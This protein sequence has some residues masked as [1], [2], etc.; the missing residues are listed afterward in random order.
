M[1]VR[2]WALLAPL[3]VLALSSCAAP[4]GNAQTDQAAAEAARRISFPRQHSADALVRAAVGTSG[5]QGGFSV[6]QAKDLDAHDLSDPLARLVFRVHQPGGLSG[7]VRS[8][9]VTACYEVMFNWY[10]VKGSPRRIDCPSRVTAIL[11]TP[12]P[13]TAGVVI[14]TGFDATL[15]KLLTSLPTGLTGE[16]VEGRVISALPDPHIDAV[17]GLQVLPPSVAAGLDGADVG[18]SV[19]EADDRHCLLGARI[20]GHVTVWRPSRVQLQPGELTCDPQT[21]LALAGLHP[22]H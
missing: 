7:F 12:L 4:P 5:S 10:G 2:R 3:V 14:P 1:R 8:D 16:Q 13:P 9:P 11:P 22:P 19:W 17:T 15:R 18:V 21:A 6:V 20:A